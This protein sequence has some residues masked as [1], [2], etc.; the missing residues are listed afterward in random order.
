[1][2]ICTRA[3]ETT[4]AHSIN[5]AL[6]VT[7]TRRS[8]DSTPLAGGVHRKTP[9]TLSRGSVASRYSGNVQGV[10]IQVNISRGGVPK[11]SIPEAQVTPT[12]LEGDACAHPQIHG[13]PNQ[14][15]LIISAEAI[16]DLTERGYPLFYGA[17]GEN[18]TTSGLDRTR[19]RLGQRYRLGSSIIE[20]T[21][22]RGPC[23]TLDVYGNT[24]QRELYDKSI[25]AGDATSPRWGMSGF[26]ARVIEPGMVRPNDIIALLDQ[27]V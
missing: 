4:A 23:S 26:Y 18:I 2:S 24:I 6:P 16:D 9:V 17:L 1:M 22:V 12:G 27:V 7:L 10:V 21:K 15:L 3:T 20:I 11:R 14:A 25:K 5:C 8:A 19:I 13:G